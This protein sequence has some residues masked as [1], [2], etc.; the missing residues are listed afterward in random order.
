MNK[1]LLTFI[2]VGLVFLSLSCKAKEPEKNLTSILIENREIPYT[3][4]E[5]KYQNK[6]ELS[7]EE[8]IE[9]LDSYI[10]L[11][12][13]SYAG[14]EDVL[15][16]GMDANE[17]KNQF[18]RKYN[19]E[20]KIKIEDFYLAL[21]SAFLP[22]VQDSHANLTYN[23]NYN[24]F[25]EK[26]QLFF[27]DVF[28]QKKD[29]SYYVLAGNQKKI[30]AGAKFN[31][32]EK[33]LF[34]YP[35]KGE[36]TYRIGC[37]QAENNDS[38]RIKF[39]NQEFSL[40][41]KKVESVDEPCLYFVRSTDKTAYI[42]YNRCDFENDTE[43]SYQHEFSNSA[44][45]YKDKDFLIVDL[46]GNY[47]G[48]NYYLMKFLAELYNQKFELND[49]PSAGSR[50]IYSYANIQ[51]FRYLIYAL[52]DVNNPEIKNILKDLSKYEKTINKKPQK[53]IE[54]QNQKS[55][56]LDNPEFKGKIILL[57][58]KNVASSGEDFVL[59]SDL[60][61]ANK[62]I[63]IG[64]NTS[65]CLFYGNICDYYLPNSGI[66]CRLSLSDFS[67][68]AKANKRFHGEG[69]GL[70]PDYWSTNED[71][72]DSILFVTQDQQMYEVLKDVL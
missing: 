69:N 10:Y 72:N 3:Y 67:F 1:K 8:M 38:F 66:K 16:R 28:V 47:G 50:D 17:I 14:Y 2:S 26:Y 5:N 7:F 57:T 65:G 13:S 60:I 48:D 15:S 23:G 71:L 62:V 18:Q 64:Q 36:G 44:K 49:L 12:E 9:D 24:A 59:Y 45:D 31:D 22:Y 37:L 4:D 29:S 11:L 39:D 56:S 6:T 52:T 32:D 51:A 41:V 43:L 19:K 35:A 68:S 33:Y 34:Y 21:Y 20:E 63:Q 53:I 58:D 40:P 27:S 46:R 42:K 25:I 55:V 30:P 54:S 61:F 70:Y